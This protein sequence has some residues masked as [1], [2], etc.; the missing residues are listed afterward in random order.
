MGECA[1][2][3][4][5]DQMSKKAN[6]YVESFSCSRQSF[7]FPKRV[8]SETSSSARS[9]SAQSVKYREVIPANCPEP[10]QPRG[11]EPEEYLEK[12]FIF[13]GCA[14]NNKMPLISEGANV[15]S[16]LKRRGELE[17]KDY[18]RWTNENNE[19]PLEIAIKAE[20]KVMVGIF[21]DKGD[22]WVYSDAFLTA[23]RKGNKVI[24]NFLLESGAHAYLD[25]GLKADCVLLCVK[26]GYTRLLNML[27][28]AGFCLRN[29]REGI[30]SLKSPNTPEVPRLWKGYTN[31]SLLHV[32]AGN[33]HH[34]I[35]DYLINLNVDIESVD[36]YGSKPVHLAVQG[37]V[38]CLRLLLR[39]DV[40]IEAADNEGHSPLFLAASFGN[41]SAVKL[42]V[43]NGAKLDTENDEGVSALLAAALCNHD[44][45]VEY[46]LNE[47]ATFKGVCPEKLKRY[48]GE[49]VTHFT[50]KNFL[51][52]MEQNLNWLT[53]YMLEKAGN[54]LP[55]TRIRLHLGVDP[56]IILYE[57]VRGRHRDILKLLE[58]LDYLE[59]TAALELDCSCLKAFQETIMKYA[60]PKRLPRTVL[61]KALQQNL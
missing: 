53:L 55:S 24:L 35:T 58:E 14:L 56:N 40:D 32:A 21:L 51:P 61:F 16:E 59:K 60:Y 30:V 3:L 2:I 44:M 54:I 13:C 47:G 26:N 41:L 4:V 8:I 18:L 28:E 20:N 17:N 7:K 36:S 48:I 39:A 25:V 29:L 38:E 15:V 1:S 50:F 52:E 6:N 19:T 57:A 34:Q 22:D 43:E 5:Q 45:I 49:V 10:C 9:P 23:C 31:G 37:G 27:R 42:L 11:L 33:G 12:L 46:L